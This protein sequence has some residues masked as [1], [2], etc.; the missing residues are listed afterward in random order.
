MRALCSGHRRLK[1]IFE[2]LS[3]ARYSRTGS[4]TI[5]KLIVPFQIE[6]GMSH[7]AVFF[8]ARLA[9]R[10]VDRS[11]KS[12]KWWPERSG[13]D[14]GPLRVVRDGALGE[15]RRQCAGRRD[16]VVELAQRC[17]VVAAR[18]REPARADVEDLEHPGE[19]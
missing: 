16:R 11:V 7:L 1:E 6:R 4:A 19:V 17:D 12:G 2:L 14:G 15:G 10:S 13:A 3:V 8:S 5:P 18:A 9:A